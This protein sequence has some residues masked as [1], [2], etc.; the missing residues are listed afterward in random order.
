MV[1]GIRNGTHARTTAGLLALLLEEVQA[2]FGDSFHFRSHLRVVFEN[3]VK[4]TRAQ[5]KRV[6]CG[7][8]DHARYPPSVCEKANF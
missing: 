5:D 4:I 6:T 3:L 8:R 7:G 1:S 2:F